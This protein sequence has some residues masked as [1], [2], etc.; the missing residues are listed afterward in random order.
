MFRSLLVAAVLAASVVPAAAETQ[1]RVLANR[2]AVTTDKITFFIGYLLWL[3]S[4]GNKRIGRRITATG[5]QSN[6]Q[7]G[8]SAAYLMYAKYDV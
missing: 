6:L 4:R 1:S 8:L 7:A 3:K 2:A 5:Q